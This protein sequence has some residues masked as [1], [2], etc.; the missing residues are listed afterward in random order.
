MSSSS[1]LVSNSLT[2]SPSRFLPYVGYVTIA[3]VCSP[4]SP[5]LILGSANDTDVSLALF[6]ERLPTIEVCAFGWTGSSGSRTTRMSGV[7]F[8]QPSFISLSQYVAEMYMEPI[9]NSGIFH[10]P[11]GSYSRPGRQ[12]HS[13]LE[14]L[15]LST[16]SLV[17]EWRLQLIGASYLSL[18]N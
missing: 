16:N 4:C 11:H 2:V 3:M 10:D 14:C 18:V 12:R 6:V 9:R 7:P 5:S 1:N 15:R 8:Q 13:V 17:M